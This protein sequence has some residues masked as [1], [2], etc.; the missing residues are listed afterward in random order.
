M[1]RLR[2]AIFN[3]GVY[4]LT[5]SVES[6]IV[7]PANPLTKF[8]VGAAMLRA[9][10]HHPITISHYIVNGTHIHMI[11]RVWNPEDIPGFMERFKTESAHYINRALGRT[12]HTIWCSSYDSPRLLNIDDVVDKIVYTY[13]NPVKDGLIHSINNYPGMSSWSSF[14]S[15]RSHIRAQLIGRDQMFE[16][17]QSLN[18]SGFRRKTKL[19]SQLAGKPR[20]LP[21]DCNDWLKA[22]GVEE[23]EEVDHINS[24]I[25]ESILKKE[26]EIQKEFV[27]NDR[28]FMGAKQ[29][30]NQGIYLEYTSK[31]SGRKMWCISSDIK[32]RKIYL[33]FVK[34]LAKEAKEVYFKWK[35]GATDLAM[36]IGMFP[37]RM[38]LQANLI[39]E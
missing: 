11:V 35:T 38:P 1:P 9:I 22:F 2:K 32:E 28:Q 3:N 5:L 12:K 24:N 27:D 8:I 6:G 21:I 20:V 34:R 19:L 33:S 23:R 26:D 4:F 7:L 31:R 15:T 37:P 13:T 10:R 16:I 17:D 14:K 25:R 36:P 30:R 29:L 18:E 39:F